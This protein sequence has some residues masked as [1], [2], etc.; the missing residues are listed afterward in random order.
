MHIQYLYGVLRIFTT[1]LTA[2]SVYYSAHQSNLSEIFMNKEHFQQQILSI[3]HYI[4]YRCKKSN[5]N[6]YLSNLQK[7][8]QTT[9]AKHLRQ[10]LVIRYETMIK[11][12]KYP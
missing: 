4:F 2:G 8:N 12:T 10:C 7:A 9:I 5:H 11:G 3:A 6:M 1:T